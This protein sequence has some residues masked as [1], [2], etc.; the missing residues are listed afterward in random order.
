MELIVSILL[1]LFGMLA[2]LMFW[3]ALKDND[4]LMVI[5]GFGAGLPLMFFLAG[6]LVFAKHV[7]IL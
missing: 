4:G 5:C 7:G 6:V 1:M 3:Q 2:F